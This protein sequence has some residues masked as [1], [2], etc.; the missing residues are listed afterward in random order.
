MLLDIADSK[1][2]KI[3]SSS[4]FGETLRQTLRHSVPQA[5]SR[6]GGKRLN[7]R[8][9]DFKS[10]SGGDLRLQSWREEAD[11]SVLSQPVSTWEGCGAPTAWVCAFHEGP[12]CVWGWG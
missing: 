3:K 2:N 1:E 10:P 8:R 9:L 12:V 11:M 7:Y 6:R 4:L 5:L